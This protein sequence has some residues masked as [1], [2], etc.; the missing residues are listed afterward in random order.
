[1]WELTEWLEFS[2][3]ADGPPGLHQRANHALVRQSVE[4]RRVKS[5]KGP[6]ADE[7]WVNGVRTATVVIRSLR[8]WHDPTAPGPPDRKQNV[9]T[10]IVRESRAYKLSENLHSHWETEV[11]K[12]NIVSIVHNN[13]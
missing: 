11:R 1:M 6:S 2:V 8:D 7:H 12:W 10:D 4:V 3:T 13:G 5:K 9:Q